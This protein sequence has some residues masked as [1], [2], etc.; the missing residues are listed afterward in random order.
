[1]ELGWKPNST[2]RGVWV[3]VKN[4]V[5]AYINLSTDDIIDMSKSEWPIDKLQ[6]R[7]G[8]LFSFKIKRGI[9]LQFLNSRIIQ[10]EYGIS[11]DQT[12]HIIKSI[13]DKYFDK[14]EKIKDELSPFH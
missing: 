11:I 5:T 2:C 9:E 10:S 1:M 8:D 12:D 4:N 7:F 13:L 6:N 3:Y 14:D